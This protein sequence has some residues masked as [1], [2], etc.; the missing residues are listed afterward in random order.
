MSFRYREGRRG[1]G[2]AISVNIQSLM[3][4]DNAVVGT[5][6]GV[7]EFIDG[8]EDVLVAGHIVEGIGTVFLNPTY[9]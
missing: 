9:V 7:D 6:V 5:Y 3:C 8:R 4:A 2:G 1:E